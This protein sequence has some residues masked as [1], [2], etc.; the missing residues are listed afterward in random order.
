MDT[1]HEEKERCQ[2]FNPLAIMCKHSLLQKRQTFLENKYTFIENLTF[3]L[4]ITEKS[5]LQEKKNNPLPFSMLDTCV[6][7]LL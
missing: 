5:F 1:A 3:F 2:H 7:G 6:Y 4:L